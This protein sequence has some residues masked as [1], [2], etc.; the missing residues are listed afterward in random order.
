MIAIPNRILC[1]QSRRSWMSRLGRE[2]S[3]TG[4]LLNFG[5]WDK[6]QALPSPKAVVDGLRMVTGLADAHPGMGTVAEGG[7]CIGRY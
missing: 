5:S 4:G 7:M 6:Y 2:A 3:L 1:I